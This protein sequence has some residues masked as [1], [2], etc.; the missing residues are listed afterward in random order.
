LVTIAGDAR[1]LFP[2][3][4]VR[5]PNRCVLSTDMKAILALY[6][7]MRSRLDEQSILEY[8]SCHVLYENGTLFED[9]ELL[10]EAAL[11]RFHVSDPSDWTVES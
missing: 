8:L 5:D 3:Y 11:A 2:L 7:D 4:F 9:I 10:P 1:G 6:P